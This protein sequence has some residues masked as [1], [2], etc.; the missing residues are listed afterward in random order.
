M[1]LWRL[2]AAR[3]ASASV[4]LCGALETEKLLRNNPEKTARHSSRC[5]LT[6]DMAARCELSDVDDGTVLTLEKLYA[7]LP[8]V[9]DIPIVEQNQIDDSGGSEIY[10]E[11]T[12]RGVR[13]V[14]ELLSPRKDDVF[15]DLGSG[16]GRF[17][18]QAALEWPCSHAVGIELSRTRHRVGEVALS[19][20]AP[21]VRQRATLRCADMLAC[22]G[23]EDA[24][25]IYVASLV[26]DD[27]FMR[28]LGTRLSQLPRLR[29]IASLR[30]FP[31]GALPEFVP[32]KRNAA[33]DSDPATLRE[34]VEATWGATRV[35]IYAR[36]T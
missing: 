4:A 32:A 20:T 35:F 22:E 3:L 2:R 23:C 28:Q 25:L 13:E 26:F 36:E 14:R 33:P 10:G 24:T 7:R 29:A 30:P 21:F 5:E 11:L 15:Y 27:A 8:D 6:D 16:A 12:P 34:R 17:V 1:T 18:L 19:R 31:P 9:N